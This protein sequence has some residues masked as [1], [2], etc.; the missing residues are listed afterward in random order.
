MLTWP[1]YADP[2]LV[3][4]FEKRHDVEVQVSYIA[5]DDE[6][7]A[8]VSQAGGGDF[9]LFAVNTAELQRYIDKGLAVPIRIDNIPN[10]GN[11]LP[12]FRELSSIPGITR[13]GNL[14]AVPYT[15]SEMGLIYNREKVKVPPTSMAA[16]WDPD[17]RGRVL[18]FDAS[19]HNFSIA[20]LL[21]GAR[22]PFQLDDSEFEQAVDK[23]IAL[24]RNVLSFYRTPEEAV[25][26]YLNNDVALVFGNY[27]TQ[28]VKQLLAAGADIGYSVPNEGALA[29]LDCWSI[30]AGVNNRG[31]AEAW[32]NY[33]L[34][35]TV[36]EALTGRHG[37]ANT[38]TPVPSSKVEDKI[39][40]LEP[41]EDY[42]KRE[43]LWNR[44]RSGEPPE[45]F[46]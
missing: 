28:Q 30:S 44:I 31:L 1:G 27:G 26:L 5:S 41:L 7:W 29:W 9:D 23:L 3:E 8:K 45:A 36:S 39:I 40:W 11:Q 21:L 17:Y 46:N 15:Y 42:P 35:T 18:A 38:I 37:L 24:R 14:Y 25:D 4:V 22:N 12:R 20:G 6:L 10:H 43:R 33:T 34:E 13:G 2:D 19:N 32:I 16:M